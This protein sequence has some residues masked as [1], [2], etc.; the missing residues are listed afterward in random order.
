MHGREE[1]VLVSLGSEH[2]P[3]ERPVRPVFPDYLSVSY[4]CL[5]ANYTNLNK[6]FENYFN[7]AYRKSMELLKV[8]NSNKCSDRIAYHYLKAAKNLNGISKFIKA[9]NGMKHCY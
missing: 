3:K 5:N 2:K 9:D 8:S 1:W 4:D 6:L 7:R